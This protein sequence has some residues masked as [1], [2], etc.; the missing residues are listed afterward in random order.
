[1]TARFGGFSLAR[2]CQPQVDPKGRLKQ[3]NRRDLDWLAVPPA[4]AQL[5]MTKRTPQ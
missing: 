2:L 1:L 4:V 3:G 5:T